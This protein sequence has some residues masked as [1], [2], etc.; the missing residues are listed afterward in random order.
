MDN[1][2]ISSKFLYGT[3]RYCLSKV[4]VYNIYR[5]SGRGMSSSV[6]QEKYTDP[7]STKAQEVRVLTKATVLVGDNMCNNMLVF[8]VYNSKPVYFISMSAE[9][10]KRIEKKRKIY[11]ATLNK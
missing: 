9:N 11:D 5:K 2:F 4:L 7:R 8:S 6:Y 3:F 10:I 1:L